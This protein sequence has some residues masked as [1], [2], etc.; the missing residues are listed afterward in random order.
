MLHESKIVETCVNQGSKEM[1]SAAVTLFRCWRGDVHC[2]ALS[3]LR[4]SLS[5]AANMSTVQL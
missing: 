3:S 5:M 4:R 2:G 1:L